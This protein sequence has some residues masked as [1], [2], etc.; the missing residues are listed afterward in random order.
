MNTNTVDFNDNLSIILSV[1]YFDDA[2]ATPEFDDAPAWTEIQLTYDPFNNLFKVTCFNGE[3][4]VCSV[5]GEYDEMALV[6]S[7]MTVDASHANALFR[8]GEDMLRATIS[9]LLE[10]ALSGISFEDSEELQE[11]F[12]EE[13]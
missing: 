10:N 3:E 11:I 1:D 5:V 9:D 6:L 7:N 4:E 12:D 2:N 8:V 13:C